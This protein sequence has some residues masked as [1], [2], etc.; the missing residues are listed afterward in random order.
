MA[1]SKHT[2]EEK[3]N[4]VT[5][6]RQMMREGVEFRSV[7]TFLGVR[8]DALRRWLNSQTRDWLFPKVEN[9]GRTR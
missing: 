2:P 3:Q 8:P 6:A 1:R 5:A 9:I 4:L 7:A